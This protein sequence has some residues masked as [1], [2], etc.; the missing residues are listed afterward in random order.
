MQA[1]EQCKAFLNVQRTRHR[2]RMDGA[3]GSSAR[4]GRRRI[5]PHLPG[6]AQERESRN[7][8]RRSLLDPHCATLHSLSLTI[9]SRRSVWRPP[10]S[11]KLCK[12]WPV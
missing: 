8:N 7:R 4:N 3:Q 12:S 1:W 2:I 10:F 6:T 11:I 9:S 5:H